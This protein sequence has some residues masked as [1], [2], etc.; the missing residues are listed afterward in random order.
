MKRRADSGFTLMELMVVMVII[1]IIAG[2]VMGVA[3]ITIQ[4]GNRGR[5]QGEIAGL[6]AAAERYKTDNGDY[7]R[8]D[9]IT[10]DSKGLAPPIDP[11]T[12]GDP[13][14]RKY[15]TAS[16][17]LYGQLS[18]DGDLDGKAG[19][20]GAKSYI[21]FTPGM[22]EKSTA[23]TQSTQVRF[24]KDPFGYSYGYCTQAMRMEELYKERILTEK[25]PDAKKGLER[26]EKKYG[27]NAG[28]FDLWSTGG[29]KKDPTSSVSVQ[30]KWV[31]N[32]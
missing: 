32:W 25:N 23:G 16:Q 26:T 30:A 4:K 6:T 18:G 8:E 2:L 5:A 22:I 11:R 27:Y 10:E 15:E 28:I 1:A 20:N 17:F 3:G 29:L 19:D 21:N 7:P 24:I 13:T 31:K 9:T 14:T 12:D